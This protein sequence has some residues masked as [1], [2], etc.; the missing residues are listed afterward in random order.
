MNNYTPDYIRKEL[1]LSDIPVK[2]KFGVAHGGKGSSA[3]LARQTARALLRGEVEKV[4]FA[5]GV[6]VFDPLTLAGIFASHSAYFTQEGLKTGFKRAVEFLSPK[7]E[8]VLMADI[9]M[10]EGVR[11]RDIIIEGNGRPTSRH[12]GQNVD[13]LISQTDGVAQDIVQEGAIKVFGLAY[14]TLRACSVWERKLNRDR[15]GSVIIVPRS[16]YPYG[17]TLENWHLSNDIRERIVYPEMAKIDPNNP[18]SHLYTTND[19]AHYDPESHRERALKALPKI[20]IQ[21]P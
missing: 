15:D 16:F 12:T 20:N 3:E 10:Q 6:K 18:S 13:F 17:F 9:A 19:V 4:I 21:G 5:G 8:A 14:N 11:A 7:K 1:F 2:T